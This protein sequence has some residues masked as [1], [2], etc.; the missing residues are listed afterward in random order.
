MG[1]VDQEQGE[2][3]GA[4]QGTQKGEHAG[5]LAGVVLVDA[6][7]AHKG[8]ASSK[9]RCS[10]PRSRVVRSSNRGFS[11]SVREVSGW[12]VPRSATADGILNETVSAL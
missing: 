7:Q 8:T 10:A 12:I 9:P 3:I 1:V 11:T 6:M 2:L 5:D 4:L